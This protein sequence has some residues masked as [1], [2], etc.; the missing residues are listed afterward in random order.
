MFAV[1]GRQANQPCTHSCTLQQMQNFRVLNQQELLCLPAAAAPL[2]YKQSHQTHVLC[3]QRWTSGSTPP[4]TLCGLHPQGTCALL[5]R[6]LF[7]GR[8]QTEHVLVPPRSELGSL[9]PSTGSQDGLC[10][11]N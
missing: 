11:S 2:T 6:V 8:R 10:D 5:G 1:W 7:Y 4:I 9:T 3:G